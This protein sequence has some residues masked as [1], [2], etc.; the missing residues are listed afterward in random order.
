MTDGMGQKTGSSPRGSDNSNSFDNDNNNNN[1]KHDKIRFRRN[2]RHADVYHPC[3]Q[4]GYKYSSLPDVSG[5]NA[6]DEKKDGRKEH[7]AADAAYTPPTGRKMTATIIAPR[8]DDFGSSFEEKRSSIISPDDD[9]D[10]DKDDYSKNN[11]DN[12]QQPRPQQQNQYSGSSPLSSSERGGETSLC[13]PA[14]LRTAPNRESITGFE[15]EKRSSS[16]EVPSASDCDEQQQQ[17]QGQ[18]QSQQ[19]YHHGHSNHNNRTT[20]SNPLSLSVL[21][22]S[23]KGGGIVVLSVESSMSHTEASTVV[24]A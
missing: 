7:A 16:T 4:C 20:T 21:S 10:N 14:T 3:P 23:P 17:K 8:M 2:P 15:E 19:K 22:S 1:K 24:D 18:D 13:E 11:Y 6:E 9:D 12:Q 5:I